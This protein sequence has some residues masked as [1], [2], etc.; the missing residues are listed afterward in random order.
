MT[1]PLVNVTGLD[2]IVLVVADVEA[3]LAF[4][5]DKLGLP[6]ERVEEWRAG[7]VTFPS[8]RI[9]DHTIIDLFAGEPSGA[10]L[11]HFAMAV[12][13]DTDLGAVVDSGQF[14]IVTAP[15]T[16]WGA[17]GDGLSLYVRDPDENTV[18]LKRYDA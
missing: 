3:S 15:V 12:T 8:A 14:E 4:Y 1:E 13:P 17:R 11:D 2:H 16:R 7:E 5:C 18:E 6:G 9:N 10:N